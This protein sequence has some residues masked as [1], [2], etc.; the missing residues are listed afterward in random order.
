MHGYEG[1]TQGWRMRRTQ[2][3]K[4]KFGGRARAEELV[5]QRRTRFSS[6]RRGG[7]EVR[8]NQPYRAARTL[9]LLAWPSASYFLE[10]VTWRRKRRG[11]AWGDCIPGFCR[12]YD[13]YYGR[14]RYLR[15]PWA[16]LI[17]SH[18]WKT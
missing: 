13:D 7:M 5:R 15:V 3:T 18:I 12:L 2:K 9:P 1:A 11:G 16:L 6:V 17:S 14:F 10:R 8:G 4:G